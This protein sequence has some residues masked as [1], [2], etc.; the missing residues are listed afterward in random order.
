MDGCELVIDHAGWAAGSWIG[1][2]SVR[3][4]AESVS[5][6]DFHRGRRWPVNNQSK[7]VCL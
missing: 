6:V 2:D 3:M 5:S 4:A 1:L 7:F